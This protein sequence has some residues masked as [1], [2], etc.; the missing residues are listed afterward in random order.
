VAKQVSVS[1]DEAHVRVVRR[2]MRKV[3]VTKFSVALQA[4]IHQ[5]DQQQK[6]AAAEEGEVQASDDIAISEQ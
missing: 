2:Y 4:I 5:W 1:L 6:A 3:G